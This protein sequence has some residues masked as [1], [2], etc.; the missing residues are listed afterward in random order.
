MELN[1]ALSV[2]E[3]A[4]LTIPNAVQLQQIFQKNI[5]RANLYSEIALIFEGKES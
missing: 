4:A 1:S 5:L 3:G 2:L